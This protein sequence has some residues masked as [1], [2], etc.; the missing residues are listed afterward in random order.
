MSGELV[1]HL[2]SVSEQLNQIVNALRDAPDAGSLDDYVVHSKQQVT[3]AWVQVE[4]R[5]LP[6]A[7][8]IR[9]LIKQRRL[10]ERYFKPG[11]FSDPAWDMLL[12][13]AAATVERKPVSVTSLCIASSAPSSTA[14]RYLGDLI[15][16]G[17]I[18]RVADK[19]DRRR[20]FVILT[21]AGLSALS[22]YFSAID[23][24]GSPTC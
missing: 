4:E 2:H 15:K 20:V 1:T 13:L 24:S 8:V 14:L 17:L 18:E 16:V 19:T 10:R 11:L 9:R 12:D 3:D 6:K 21:S 22:D 5:K 23:M 7:Q